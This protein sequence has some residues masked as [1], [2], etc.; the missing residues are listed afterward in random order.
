MRYRAT[1]A[2]DYSSFYTQNRKRRVTRRS[3][4]RSS[5]LC[6]RAVHRP[7]RQHRWAATISLRNAT[8]QRHPRRRRLQLPRSSKW[9]SDFV[10]L[11][12]MAFSR[13]QKIAAENACFTDDRKS[14]VIARRPRQLFNR[15]QSRNLVDRVVLGH[16]FRSRSVVH[17]CVSRS[18]MVPHTERRVKL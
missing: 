7:S 12:L 13:S 5:P 16:R 3:N 14:F 6:R 9:L 15:A 18:G 10:G 1:R 11:I 17:Q 2:P 8:F 4:E